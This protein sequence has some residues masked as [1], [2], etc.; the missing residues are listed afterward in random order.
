MVMPVKPIAFIIA[1]LLPS[2]AQASA[3][4]DQ[5]AKA[6]M[7]RTAHTVRYDGRY[8]TIAYPG[9][10]VPD[11]MGVCTD[12]VIRAYRKLGIDLQVRVHQDMKA[13]F[14]AYPALWGLSRPDRNIDH[15]RVPNLQTFFQ[16]Q[17]AQI[18]DDNTA[19][20]LQAGDVLTWMLPGNLPHTGIV[21]APA[22]ADRPAR[23]VHNIGYGPQ[24]TTIPSGWK[25]TGHYRYSG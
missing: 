23:I 1:V 19:S 22:S 2:L 10:D 5:L 18:D 14:S 4:G 7:E 12:V 3:K 13:D 25:R 21:V 20:A 6:A 17:G 15:R 9:G 24:E 8:L 16:R 11:T